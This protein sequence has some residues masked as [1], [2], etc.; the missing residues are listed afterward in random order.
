MIKR[1][2]SG[3]EEGK[4]QYKKKTTNQYPLGDDARNTK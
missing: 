3:R 1:E 4:E 2:S